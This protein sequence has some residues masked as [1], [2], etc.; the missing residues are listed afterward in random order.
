MSSRKKVRLS[1]D[2][3]IHLEGITY[4][5][6]RRTSM[7][8]SL[9]A[10]TTVFCML[11]TKEKY[12]GKW[13]GAVKKTLSHVPATNDFIS[14][15]EVNPAAEYVKPDMS[16]LGDLR[17]VTTSRQ[18]QRGCLLM[19]MIAVYTIRALFLSKWCS[20]TISIC[21]A[22]ASLDVQESTRVKPAR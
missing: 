17:L 9:A 22:K 8:M 1:P 2:H 21:K 19:G 6:E 4:P 13:E 20:S 3:A 5:P 14:L 11:R 18:S 12:R 16:I 7:S 15:T 10:L